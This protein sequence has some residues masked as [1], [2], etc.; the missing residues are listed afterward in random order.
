MAD[1]KLYLLGSPRIEVD[2][3]AIAIER[4]KALALLFYLVVKAEPQPR[5]TLATLLWPNL[6]Q[7]SARQALR[8]H[9]YVLYSVQNET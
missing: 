6:S 4:R 3:E 5:D 7:R 8:R 1:F 2:Q 9:L